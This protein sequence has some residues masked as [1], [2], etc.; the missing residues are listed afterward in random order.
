MLLS[1][2]QLAKELGVH[3]ET[4]RRWDKEGK[5]K[6]KR[7]GGGHRR[8]DLNQVKAMLDEEKSKEEKHTIIYARVS[9]PNR[10]DDLQRQIERL[11]TFCMAKGWEYK[12]IS[13]IGSGINYNK[14]GLKQLIEMILTNQVE[15]IV[16]NYKDRLVRFGYELIEQICNLKNV[17]IV[18][19]SQDESKTFEEE[20]TQDILSILTVYSAKL[21]GSRSHKNKKIVEEVKKIEEIINEEN[22]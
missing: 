1:A 8:F 9:T 3:I 10:K 17:E 5:I 12:T 6:A 21:Y 14:K 20:M 4:I 22:N 19:V 16:I 11:E 15:R 13:D 2:G 7:T 18:I